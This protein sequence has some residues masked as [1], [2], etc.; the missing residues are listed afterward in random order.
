MSLSL[1]KDQ[2]F[3]IYYPL[4]VDN[5]LEF[6]DLDIDNVE[7]V[8]NNSKRYDELGFGEGKIS[9]SKRGSWYIEIY[10]ESFNNLPTGQNTVYIK[11]LHKDQSIFVENTSILYVYDKYEE[12][13]Q[14]KDD[15]TP[16]D[17]LSSK[18]YTTKKIRNERF[19]I[20]KECP[21]LFKPTKTCKEC[22]CFMA[23][24]TWLSDATCPI[25]KW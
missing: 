19:D 9:I 16:L 14:D 11:I 4:P 12:G 17:L 24:K 8:I 13:I 6:N 5:S 23:M 1:Y 20:C 2:S 21:K 22:G 15:V 7:V 18:N 25:N 10:D 3:Y